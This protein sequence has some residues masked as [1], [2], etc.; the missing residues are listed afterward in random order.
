MRKLMAGLFISLDGVVNAPSNWQLPY[1]NDEIQEV[2]SNGIAQCDTV[3]LGTRTYLEF[4]ELW[5]KQGSDGPMADF[6]NHVPKYIVSSSLDTLEWTNSRLVK[7]NLAEEVARL[8]ERSGKN[9]LIPGSPRLVRSLLRDRLLDELSL[10]IIPVVVGSGLHL[11]DE[12]TEQLPLKLVQS[13]ALSN[14][15]LSVTYQSAKV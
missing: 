13:K 5:P 7:G 15:V 3:L 8:K 9:I 1:W 11:F 14:G 2:I 6:M 10:M 4:A 12:I